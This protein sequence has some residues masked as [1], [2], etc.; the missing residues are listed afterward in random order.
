L[1]WLNQNF[2]GWLQPQDALA[3]IQE[4]SIDRLTASYWLDQERANEIVQ[5]IRNGTANDLPPRS[6]VNPLTGRPDIDPADGKP[7]PVPGYMPD[8]TD[9][10]PVW[11]K[12]FSDWMKT[13]D[14][15]RQPPEA[16]TIA[17][18]VWGALK[19]LEQ[20]KA[21]QDAQLQM[22]MAQGLG[23]QNAAAPQTKGMPSLPGSSTVPAPR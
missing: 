12:V 17:R 10:V 5:A 7:M 14:F 16:Q 23:M 9:S 1:A 11:K 18:Q 2:P 8:E 21:V 6:D 22:Q 19:A 13:D 20:A 15:A 3:A 4:G